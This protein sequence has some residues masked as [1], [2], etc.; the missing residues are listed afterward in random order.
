[1]LA[2]LGTSLLANYASDFLKDTLTSLKLTF[3]G[4][5]PASPDPDIV[6]VALG[7]LG[8]TVEPPDPKPT[9]IAQPTASAAVELTSTLSTTPSLTP[10]PSLTP[11][12]ASTSTPTATRT[13]PP[14]FTPTDTAVATQTN[15]P[16]P[17][18]NETPVVSHSSGITFEEAQVGGSHS[19]SSITTDE[20]IT[21]VVGHLYLATISTKSGRGRVTAISGMGLTWTLLRAQ[22]AGRHQ[23]R[24][25]IW[26]GQ[27]SPTE[28]GSVRAELSDPRTNAIIAVSRYSGVD[29]SQPI[30]HIVSANTNGEDGSCSDGDDGDQ[31][32]LNLPI[33]AEGA[34]AFVGVA[35]RQRL[36][37]PGEGLT[38]RLEF[39][40]GSSGEAAGLVLMDLGVNSTS[41]AV[42]GSFDNEVD[43]AVIVLELLP[44]P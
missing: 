43:W 29:L 1:M 3:L 6:D 34:M 18:A 9:S 40:Y 8:S 21:A 5:R 37:F 23:T 10:V 35:K 33:S 12:S 17:T 15:T 19:S 22:C 30:G 32:S 7:D 41:V 39:Q 20:E 11:L 38:Q 36:H 28:S 27:G 25:E 14:V 42:S 24:A 4:E 13:T 31:Y 2:K 26:I 16:S 44:A